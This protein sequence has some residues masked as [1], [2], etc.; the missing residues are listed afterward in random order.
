[1]N[2]KREEESYYHGIINIF[3]EFESNSEPLRIF[4]KQ[5]AILSDLCFSKF[6]LMFRKW[7]GV[8]QEQETGTLLGSS[9]KISCGK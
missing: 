9:C 4:L 6:P 7:I 1:M 5:K 2:Q 3:K 8:R